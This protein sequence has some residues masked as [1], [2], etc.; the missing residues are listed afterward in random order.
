MAK[1]SVIVPVYNKAPFLRR[2]LDSLANQSDQSAQVI[3]VD[4][5]S[6]DGSD[7]ICAEYAKY[8]FELYLLK[9]A[10]VSA[11]RN[12]GMSKAKGEYIAFL[13]ADDAFTENAIDVMTRISRHGFNIFQF[14]QYRCHA[15]GRRKDSV[16]KGHY[17]Y[18]VLPRRWAMVWNK[19]YKRSFINRHQI[20]FVEGMQFGEDEVF[21]VKAIL[22]NDGLYQAPQTLIQHHFD[23]KK[24]LCRGELT[25]ERLEGLTDTLSEIAKRQREPEKR[26]WIEKKIKIHQ[27]SDLYRRFGYHRKPNGR[28]DVVYFV[29]EGRT[30]EELRYS[31]RSVEENWQYR[32]VW[33][34]GGGPKGITPDEHVKVAQTEPSKW[35]RVHNMLRMACMNDE[36]TEDFWLFNDDFFILKPV[37]DNMP[38]QYN[39]S[40]QAQIRRVERRHGRETSY[41]KRLKHLVATLEEAGKTQ[42]NYSVHKPI[43]I[44]R[45]KMLEV[46]DKFP[47]EP[48]TRALYGNYWEIGGEDCRDMKV[49]LPWYDVEKVEREW[50]FVSTC[51]DSFRDGNIGRYIREKFPY[52]SRFEE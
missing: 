48:M 37:D 20:R 52:K 51:D 30:N 13:D 25:L 9:H 46:L 39:G 2:C 7:A 12:Y 24:S 33:L 42:V 3:L 28:Y 27:N 35:E 38:P 31:L 8:G 26:A 45:R 49:M 50:R 22:A 36:I 41:T 32:K 11:A 43:L 18:E 47:N 44:N 17:S 5:G 21:N 23:D 40:L 1:I 4:D 15:G 14:G 16:K 29:R 6:T 34:Y 19:I 10:G